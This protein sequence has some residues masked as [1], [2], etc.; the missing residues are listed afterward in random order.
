[1]EDKPFNSEYQQN[2]WR[3]QKGN[4]KIPNE[5]CKWKHDDPNHMGCS[6]SRSKKVYSSII[7]SQETRKNIK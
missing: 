1:M 5:E 7:L 4:F 3:I 2:H 6:K